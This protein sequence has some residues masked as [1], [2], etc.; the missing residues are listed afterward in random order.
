MFTDHHRVDTD[1]MG[2]IEQSAHPPLHLH[3]RAQEGVYALYSTPFPFRL[4]AEILREYLQGRYLLVL[5]FG[6]KQMLARPDLTMAQWLRQQGLQAHS[7]RSFALLPARQLPELARLR[8]THLAFTDTFLSPDELARM[9]IDPLLVDT[10]SSP[11]WHTVLQHE[12]GGSLYWESRDDRFSHLLSRDRPLLASVLSWLLRRY[13]QAHQPNLSVLD[14]FPPL[15]HEQLWQYAGQGLAPMSG[16]VAP[17]GVELQVALGTPDRSVCVLA[18]SCLQIG[19]IQRGFTL[20][21][22]CAGWELG[23]TGSVAEE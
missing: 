23:S 14:D 9:D 7:V 6:S 11:T 21:W 10:F 1:D 16:A 20:R 4:C 22:G 19:Q 5:S 13:L 2:A 15:I 3:L 17:H 18:Q 8:Q 12:V